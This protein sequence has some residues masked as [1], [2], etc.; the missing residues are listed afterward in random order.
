VDLETIFMAV[1]LSIFIFILLLLGILVDYVTNLRKQRQII[2][3]NKR[4]RLQSILF[5]V[6]RLLNGRSVL[7]LSVVSA[8]VCLERT[9]MALNSLLNLKS[10][11]KLREIKAEIQ[12]KLANF[13]SMPSTDEHFYSL[14]PMPTTEQELK[15]TLKQSLLLTA[16]LKADLY[17]GY[18]PSDVIQDELAQ[19][20]ILKARLTS[21][22]K[23]KYAMQALASKHYDNALTLNNQ[24]IE[25][26]LEIEC[27]ND[28]VC[29]LINQTV[30][31]IELINDGIT[32]VIDEKSHS[33]YEKYKEDT[34]QP[35]ENIHE[36]DDGLGR[37]FENEY[38]GCKKT[39]YT[40]SLAK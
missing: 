26:L 30:K 15:I 1:I 24:A 31:E 27:L 32:A 2:I 39:D 36:R 40:L 19:L 12:E 18:F 14:L 3:K 17:K 22:I 38:Q 16:T 9:I 10:T 25:F 20:T 29:E 4:V 23:N 7:P 33:F 5:R 35:N 37:I 6:Q 34:R 28:N 8:V 11:K 21:A 13:R